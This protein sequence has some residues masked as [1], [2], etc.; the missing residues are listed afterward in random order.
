MSKTTIYLE[1]CEITYPFA[2]I[3]YKRI[4]SLSEMC[5]LSILERNVHAVIEKNEEAFLPMS[6]K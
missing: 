4:V 5:P 3:Q 1:F 2:S 6:L